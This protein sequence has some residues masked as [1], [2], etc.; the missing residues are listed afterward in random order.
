MSAFWHVAVTSISLSKK[1]GGKDIC[2]AYLPS[3]HFKIRTLIVQRRLAQFVSLRSG[4]KREDCFSVVE[5][6]DV[7]PMQVPESLQGSDHAI[8]I[9]PHALP[10][11]KPLKPKIVYNTHQR[12]PKRVNAPRAESPVN[13][14]LTQCVKHL[15]KTREPRCIQ[16]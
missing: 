8:A 3:R 12:F 16:C 9:E 11:S 15:P 2:N 14:C 13:L 1:A 7:K 5:S 4:L 10:L 6:A